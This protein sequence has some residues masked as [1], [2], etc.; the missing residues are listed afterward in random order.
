MM[1]DE[2]N[3]VVAQKVFLMQNLQNPNS[4]FQIREG[5]Q[6]LK[7]EQQSELFYLLT[8]TQTPTEW[9]QSDPQ[10]KMDGKIVKYIEGS[11]AIKFANALWG[12]GN[13]ELTDIA[14]A[15]EKEEKTSK[16]GSKYVNYLASVTGYLSIKWFDGTT[17]KFPTAGTG[18]N[19]RFG[20]EVKGAITDA[21][22]KGL[23]NL[24]LFSDVYGGQDHIDG[25]EI[26]K[27]GKKYLVRREKLAETVDALW[28]KALD[29]EDVDA[30]IERLDKSID[31]L[32]A[33]EHNDLVESVIRLKETVA[34][35]SPK[36]IQ[37]L[38]NQGLLKKGVN[39][40]K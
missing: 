28:E 20:D 17:K 34:K 22:K 23:A 13:W 2:T 36:D 1:K 9:I 39:D 7:P 21:I 16:A 33:T 11:T 10:F 8:V 40:G 5:I 32:K 6:T 15:R 14:I 29:I 12:V 37:D 26:E 38:M 31:V 19:I 25:A 18:K 27:D 3:L 35:K 30:F 24:G 4:F